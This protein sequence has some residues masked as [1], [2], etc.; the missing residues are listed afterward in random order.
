M[1][2]LWETGKKL[3]SNCLKFQFHYG[4]IM[5]VT[6]SCFMSFFICIS[7]PLWFDYGHEN[8]KWKYQILLFQFHYGSIMGLKKINH[9]KKRNKFQFHYG[10]IM[11]TRPQNTTG[12]GREFQFHYGSIMGSRVNYPPT[13]SDIS[14][15]LWF[16]YGLSS[17]FCFIIQ[18]SYFNSTMV[19]LWGYSV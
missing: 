11:G 9:E 19:R 6:A 3:S 17:V 4:S 7:I 8:N 10:S 16:D 18:S 12:K 15:P 2:R 14:I 13:Q 5:G 1:V